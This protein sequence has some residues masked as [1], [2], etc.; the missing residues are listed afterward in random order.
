MTELLTGTRILNNRKFTVV[1]KDDENVDM[2]YDYRVILHQEENEL[3]IDE[4]CE[5]DS[6]FC[7]A[8]MLEKC[9]MAF[10]DN[11]ENDH[12]IIIE[13]GYSMTGHECSFL[14]GDRIRA[15]DFEPMPG[16]EDAYVEGTFKGYSD[17]GRMIVTN[18]TKDTLYG[19]G[20]SFEKSP[21]REE[22]L[23]PPFGKVLF[24]E[25]NGRITKL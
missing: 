6:N 17:D 9:D 25:W 2:E 21:A 22:I 24:G 19:P 4:V 14:V 8:W 1:S 23:T 3:L 13:K 15:W 5:G 7:I 10:A 11:M 12:E 16:R 20:A 18:I